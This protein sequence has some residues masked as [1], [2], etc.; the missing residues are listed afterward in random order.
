M[1]GYEACFQVVG[2]VRHCGQDSQTKEQKQA[3]ESDS[4]KEC[5]EV[6]KVSQEDTKA[7]ARYEAQTFG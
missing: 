1:L 6:A 2:V 3:G 4:Y 7:E 5:G